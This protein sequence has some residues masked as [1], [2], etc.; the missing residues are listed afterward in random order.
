VK[1]KDI[2]I[3]ALVIGFLAMLT[4]VWFSP[5]GKNTAPDLT[6]ETTTGQK[7]NFSKLSEKKP[8]L[9][10]FWATTCRSC[11]EEMPHL[12][13][14]YEELNGK[15]LELISVT[16]DYDPPILVVGMIR[17]RSIPYPVVMDLNK[18]I[19]RAFGMTSSIT[20]TTF[21]IAPGGRI[22]MQKSGLL[23]MQ[24]LKQQIVRYL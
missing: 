12:I 22:V 2:F 20:P 6:V 16:M 1:R 13:E 17:K 21:L 8:V 4:Y 14:L 5:A 23:D 3:A 10:T 11:L 19:V 15:G 24:Q 9:V 7:I 18:Q